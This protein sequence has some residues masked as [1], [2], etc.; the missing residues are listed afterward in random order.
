MKNKW[1]CVHC[2]YA[3]DYGHADWCP[4]KGKKIGGGKCKDA[5]KISKNSLTVWEKDLYDALKLMEGR[6]IIK[7]YVIACLQA[8]LDA[9]TM[10]RV[11]DVIKQA[12]E[13]INEKETKEAT[14]V[15]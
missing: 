12:V 5:C 10:R 4:H 7:T 3:N 1:S 11:T 2:S 14:K 6:S 9:E 8:S 13:D 15:L